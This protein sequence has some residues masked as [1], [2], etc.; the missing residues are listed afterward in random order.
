D[1]RF[2][3][4]IAEPRGPVWVG[5]DYRQ[6]TIDPAAPEASLATPDS[7]NSRVTQLEFLLPS[8]NGG[9]WRFADGRIERRMTNGVESLGAYPWSRGG[10]VKIAAAC[11]DG[12][13][14][15]LVGTLGAGLFRFD[16][17]GNYSVLS[18]NNGL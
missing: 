10:K 13:G 1:S 5:T 2:R 17:K 18:T 8:Q 11:E 12:E 6:R 4:L 15:L 7:P 9:V 16:S 3:T 14:N